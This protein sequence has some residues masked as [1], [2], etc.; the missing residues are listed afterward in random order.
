MSTVS[1]N[2]DDPRLPCRTRYLTKLADFVEGEICKVLGVK[3]EIKRFQRRLERLS[4]F[5]QD[6]EQKRHQDA[7]VNAW[8]TDLKEIVYDAEDIIDL[9]TLPG[10][11]KSI[12]PSSSSSS[13]AVSSPFALL[14]SCFACT[15][16]RHEIAVSFERLNDRLKEIQDDH[17]IIARLGL[18]T[19]LQWPQEHPTRSRR[20]TSLEVR[21]DI[22]GAGIEDV[23][24]FLVERYLTKLADFVEGEICK[25][26]GVKEEI[27]RFQRR[28]E[29]LSPFLQD[30]EQKRHQ[31]AGVNVWLTDLKEIVYDAEDIIDL[32][33]LS[34]G[35][36]SIHPSSSS[37]YAVSAPFALLASCFACT[38]SRHEIAV[39]FERLN[40]R[41]KEIQDDH[42]IIASLGSLTRLQWPQEHPTRSRRTTSLEVR[43]DIV[44][45]GIEDAAQ[46][47]ISMILKHDHKQNDVFGIVGMGGM[48][49]TT[50]AH[51]IFH[52]ERIK[53]DFPTCIWIHVSKNY[54]RIEL[55]KQMLKQ[56]QGSDDGGQSIKELESNVAGALVNRFFIVLDDV[57][58]VNVWTDVLR[59]PILNAKSSGIILVTGRHEKVMKDIRAGHIHHVQRMNE[60]DGL[61][62]FHKVVFEDE[63]NENPEL[64]EI[65]AK[66]VSK[67][68]GLPLAIKAIAGM[69]ISKKRTRRE[70]ERVLESD[71]W[72]MRDN[73]DELPRALYLSYE[74]LSSVLK[75]CFLCCASY[76]DVADR[77][78]LVRLWIAEGLI[79]VPNGEMEE[80]A[81]YYYKELVMR[82]L[83]QLDPTYADQMFYSMD[84]LL[85][86]LGNN[87]IGDE[88]LVI[89]DGRV[90]DT[91]PNPLTKIRRLWMSSKGDTL[92]LP[93]AVLEQ[94]C[95][96][97]LRLS[98]S[99]EIKT[100]EDEAA[101][102][103]A[104]K[105]LRVLDVSDTQIERLPDFIFMNLL[106]LR[107]LDLDR[108]KIRELPESIGRLANLQTLNI[109]GCK[110]LRSLPKAV[111]SLGML[112]CLRAKGTPLTHLP[113]GMG[114]LTNLNHI[115]EFIVGHGD[116]PS[117]VD[118]GC[119]LEELRS[120]SKLRFLNAVKLEKATMTG[121]SVLENKSWLRHLSL[122]WTNRDGG[123]KE[124]AEKTCSGLLPP[125]S[126][127][128][129]C[130]LNFPG[131]RFPNWMMSTSVLGASFPRLE[132]LNLWNFPCCTELPPLGQ[133]P[134]LKFLEIKGASAVR[135]VGPEFLDA[136]SPQAVAFPRLESLRFLNMPNWEEW[137]LNAASEE[138]GENQERSPKLFPRLK[139]CL[140]IACPKL[141]GLPESIY[142]A[143][144]LKKIFFSTSD[145][146][147]EVEFRKRETIEMDDCPDFILMRYSTEL[148]HWLLDRINRKR[149]EK[150]SELPSR[151]VIVV[152]ADEIIIQQNRQVDA[153]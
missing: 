50:L 127:E 112:R 143:A 64:D 76:I 133:L 101:A 89:S 117:N 113:R 15:K 22:V 12:H 129:L 95:L 19:S 47:L 23:A 137:T 148:P 48:G 120:L 65:A 75:Q 130:L 84:D 14:A 99:S 60:D 37:S 63:E 34:G 18:L 59:N 126:L 152:K 102:L 105:N 13:S 11:D 77:N 27:K 49:K 149:N 147:S 9:Y 110:S 4:P 1:T 35:D 7:G 121:T 86:A 135:K 39:S 67:C 138:A 116:S 145:Q 144:R 132:I 107:Y 42:K 125:P 93:G 10:G 136:D 52:D 40:D 91:N 104:L 57:W 25:V 38:K 58:S 20:T 46:T 41:L 109:A 106:L 90:A 17:K 2:G 70:W 82:N 81:E 53:N 68:D 78:D 150:N 87:L 36:K 31:D 97:V 128:E 122:S 28:L 131:R 103:P 100:I 43:A 66:I 24:D 151:M 69:L 114:R 94:K 45:A 111:T 79:H 44:G 115:E 30:A 21:A 96:R 140:F 33:T 56:A 153:V 85:R 119:D 55:L 72:R 26:L 141:R 98:D 71:L 118:D 8:L 73:E 29:R 80:V 88:A 61:E 32:Y 5:L 74:D 139:V 123:E 16:S 54:M 142:C 51:K 124:A 108:T 146:L 6:A 92:R 83:L 134:R 62:L 3:E